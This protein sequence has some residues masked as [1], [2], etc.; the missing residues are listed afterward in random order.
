MAVTRQTAATEQAAPG[1]ARAIFLDKDGTLVENVPYNIDP[2]RVTLCPR[3]V[4]GLQLLQH[5]RFTLFIVS[6]QPG[7]AKG[8]F[9]EHE[10]LRLLRYL[11]QLL[12][13]HGIAIAGAYY[14]PH[15]ADGVVTRWATLCTCRKPMPGMLLRAAH[16]HDIELARSWMI[17][18]ILHDVEAGHRAGCQSA[19]IDNGNE[20]LWEYT[21]LRIPD[22]IA[23]DLHAAAK[24]I[25]RRD[26]ADFPRPGQSV[27]Q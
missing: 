16:E 6:N 25:I 14:C 22:L 27:P 13:R 3:A 11:I 10:L 5:H 4:Q 21:A 20:T 23:T 8:Y 9:A 26:G 7:I 19:L 24:A 2:D 1:R 15:S 18:D 12:A 17:G